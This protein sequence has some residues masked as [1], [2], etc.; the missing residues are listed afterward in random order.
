MKNHRVIQLSNEGVFQIAARWEVQARYAVRRV[1]PEHVLPPGTWLLDLGAVQEGW[2][3]GV[4]YHYRTVQGELL[5]RSRPLPKSAYT[6]VR[7][8]EA[9]RAMQA[10][11][12][13]EVQLQEDLGL[14]WEVMQPGLP[15]F[16]L[17][18]CP[19]CSGT[20]FTSLEG[21]STWC[22][23]C[24]ARFLVRS[25][26]GDPGFVVDVSWEYY[27]PSA[28]LY[29]LPRTRTLRS[30]LVL[31]DSADPRDM[32]QEDCAG[33]CRAGHVL[34]TDG[35]TGLRA[36]LHLCKVGTLYDWR[37]IYGEVPAPEDLEG[38]MAWEIDGQR[39]P[40]SATLRSLPL[41]G[42][43]GRRWQARAFCWRRSTPPRRAPL[44]NCSKNGSWL[45]R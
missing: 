20:S 5:A 2:M 36:G 17:I 11:R 3:G 43:S 22:D 23:R 37:Q 42:K 30:T 41:K 31:K 9:L 1:G 33:D 21:A 28:A 29:L 4:E 25:T 19:L 13:L 40:F 35:S 14:N 18:R 39:W 44:R 26:A 7:N 27:D 32:S 45:L 6:P 10:F 12:S 16:A 34:L 24:N 8:P 38:S 15:P